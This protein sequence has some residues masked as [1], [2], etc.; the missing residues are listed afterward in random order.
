MNK[1]SSKEKQKE[2]LAIKQGKAYNDALDFMKKE[3][4]TAAQ[5]TKEDV[6]VTVAVEKAEG[7]YKVQADGSLD[8]IT[9]S[10]QDNLHI[11]VIVQDKKDK[12]FIPHLPVFVTLKNSQGDLI[13][14]EKQDFLW[15]PFLYHYGKNWHI[16]KKDNYSLEV[17]IKQP[18]FGR[19]DEVKGKKYQKDVKIVF[20]KLQLTPGR[21]PHGSE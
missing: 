19:H 9:P 2:E 17:F 15:H 10:I 20:S 14:M 5:Q 1:N 13:G 4:S 7:F 16:P 3:T 8:W 12:R 11:E 6:I 21:K 18:L